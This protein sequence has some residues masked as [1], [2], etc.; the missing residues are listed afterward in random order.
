MWPFFILENVYESSYL[1]DQQSD[2]VIQY[3]TLFDL[4]TL[5]KKN[6]CLLNVFLYQY[7]PPK[8]KHHM[9]LHAINVRIPSCYMLQ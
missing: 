3:F 1:W 5:L 9:F 7:V 4:S 2:I 6:N 8:T